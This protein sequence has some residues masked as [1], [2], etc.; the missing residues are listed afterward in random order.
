MTSEELLK[1]DSAPYTSEMERIQTLMEAQGDTGAIPEQNHYRAT[2][3][4]RTTI[5]VIARVWGVKV[6]TSVEKINENSYLV[7]YRK[8]EA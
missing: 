8:V 6:K 3:P 7:W 4:T 1:L 2:S 5:H